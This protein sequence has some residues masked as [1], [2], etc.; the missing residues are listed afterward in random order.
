[1]TAVDG[2]ILVVDDEPQILHV[3]RSVLEDEGFAVRTAASGEQAL[4]YG[5]RPRLVVLDWMLP[6]QNG[7]DVAKLLRAQ[8]G[9]DLP[10][11]IITADGRAAEK[12]HSVDAVGYVRKPFNLDELVSAVRQGLP[13]VN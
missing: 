2:H 3:V 9:Q 11:L 4:G 12:A 5:A 10:I 13:S 6:G 8:H 1:M 7:A